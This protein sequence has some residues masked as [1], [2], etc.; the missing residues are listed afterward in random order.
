MKIKLLFAVLFISLLGNAQDTTYSKVFHR[1]NDNISV[2]ATAICPSYDEG[3]IIGCQYNNLQ[4][5]AML[6][7]DSIGDQIWFNA[8]QYDLSVYEGVRY[9]Q[10]IQTFDSSYVISGRVV[11][12]ADSKH[13][14]YCLKIDQNGVEQWSISFG[15]SNQY[16]CEKVVV[17]ETFDSSYVITWNDLYDNHV[18]V[19]K[20]NS[21]GGQVWSKEFEGLSDYQIR[22][23]EELEDSSLLIAGHSSNAS[24]TTG[25]LMKLQSNGQIL[26]SKSYDNFA[27]DQLLI[28]GARIL[29]S[30]K[31]LTW[32]EVGVAEID[33]SGS[34]NWMKTS[35]NMY[36]YD[37]LQPSHIH[38]V[39]DSSFVLSSGS[40][41]FTFSHVS[42][43]GDTGQAIQHAEIY[44]EI[45]DALARPDNGYFMVGNGPLWGL[46][47]DATPH[48]G[49]NCTDSLFQT[50]TLET[51]LWAYLGPHGNVS[52]SNVN[53]I[54][55]N[56]T[57]SP[58]EGQLGMISI[59][60]SLYS[61]E[62][63]VKFLGEIVETEEII[64]NVFPNV[65]T[66]IFNFE[67][68]ETQGYQLIITDISGKEIECKSIEASS[69]TADLSTEKSGIYFYKV[70]SSDGRSTSG[71]LMLM[72]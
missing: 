3:Y 19:A 50:S 15:A 49:V 36:F 38:K 42:I 21:S 10:I 13:D 29:I 28:D 35:Y 72:K 23:I 66:G 11:N 48:I 59:T 62:G 43:I 69:F 47:N 20:V 54:I 67:L 63:C 7:V 17:T 25:I 9:D 33:T 64:V 51:C 8:Y 14:A 2:K 53:D 41:D 22:S 56:E 46:K 57:G 52:Y 26:W 24:G 16:G 39:N 6:S 55:L 27:L 40:Q 31:D 18:Y 60:D 4:Q 45:L 71:K 12:P 58:V 5:G 44:M 70:V 37:I 30:G 32:Y 34:I 61:Y 68:N 1:M 65:S